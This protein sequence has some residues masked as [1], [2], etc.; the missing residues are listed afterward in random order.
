MCRLFPSAP[1]P[2]TKNAVALFVPGKGVQRDSVTG[3][4]LK[5][6]GQEKGKTGNTF[7]YDS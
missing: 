1:R 3:K 6:R 4:P 7:R 2:Y 5:N